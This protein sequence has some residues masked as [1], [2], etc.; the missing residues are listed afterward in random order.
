MIAKLSRALWVLALTMGLAACHTR[1]PA[2]VTPEQRAKI[3]TVALAVALNDQWRWEDHNFLIFDK[4]TVTSTDWRLADR[5]RNL[6]RTAL[7]KQYTLVPLPAGSERQVAAMT[8]TSEE[9]P[10]MIDIVSR[11]AFR[12]DAVVLIS[13]GFHHFGQVRNGPPYI[14]GLGIHHTTYLF[15]DYVLIY[16]VLDFDIIDGKTST[17]MASFTSV[18]P[19]DKDGRVPFSFLTEPGGRKIVSDWTDR[20]E[21]QPESVRA[22]IRASFYEFIDASVPFTLRK[23]GVLR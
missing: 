23:R 17:L 2:A 5:V 14:S 4:K 1:P 20:F 16:S 12:P 13:P 10:K 6:A 9:V 18:I 7:A 21:E 22:A 8:A 11:M 19:S 15:Q 3:K